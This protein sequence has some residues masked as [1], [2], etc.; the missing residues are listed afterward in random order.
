MIR[1]FS[2]KISVTAHGYDF[3]DIEKNGFYNECNI[4]DISKN[5]HESKKNFYYSQSKWI[6]AGILSVITV[7]IVAVGMFYRSECISNTALMVHPTHS[8]QL[9]DDSLL[10][11]RLYTDCIANKRGNIICAT[12]YV[13]F[14]VAHENKFTNCIKD[15]QHL[16]RSVYKPENY[17]TESN[18]IATV[19]ESDGGRACVYAAKNGL[20]DCGSF[21]HVLAFEETLFS[22]AVLDCKNDVIMDNSKAVLDCKNDVIMDDSKAVLDCKNDVIMDKCIGV[23]IDS[24]RS[25]DSDQCKF[26]CQGRVNA[27]IHGYA[28]LKDNDILFRAIESNTMHSRLFDICVQSCESAKSLMCNGRLLKYGDKSDEFNECLYRFDEA[29]YLTRN[30]QSLVDA[31]DSHPKGYEMF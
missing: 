21:E 20:P 5:Y 11:E 31:F 26:K 23:R 10:K 4:F 2:S 25:C 17:L 24:S 28:V 27:D 15:L 7:A 16:T 13:R 9:V 30:T 29:T 18:N 8:K 14:A 3:L 1:I 22:K 6:I 12:D 19:C